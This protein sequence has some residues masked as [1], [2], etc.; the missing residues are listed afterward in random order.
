MTSF[1]GISVE[2]LPTCERSHRSKVGN[3]LLESIKNIKLKS[4]LKSFNLI[5]LAIKNRKTLVPIRMII[6]SMPLGWE[7]LVKPHHYQH[8]YAS[9]KAHNR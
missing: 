2:D 1:I 8:V 7:T 4:G 5:G 9:S 3:S 6:N